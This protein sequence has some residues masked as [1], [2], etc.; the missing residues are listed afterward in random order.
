MAS[1]MRSLGVIGGI[2]SVIVALFC[3]KYFM[4]PKNVDQENVVPTASPEN[5]L[6]KVQKLSRVEPVRVSYDI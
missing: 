3:A 4:I 2:L 5:E 6:N 1:T